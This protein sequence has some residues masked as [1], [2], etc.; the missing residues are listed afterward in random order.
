[1]MTCSIWS[2]V[3]VRGAPGRGSS[4]RPLSRSDTKRPRHLH[5]VAGVT[6]RRRATTLLSRP[7]PHA[8]MMRARRATW[9]ADRE[10]CA[11]DSNRRR[12]SPVKINATLGRPVRMLASL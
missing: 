2:S 11:N 3:I 6:W 4:Y 1:M 8:K 7:S 9:G 12:S 10:R 5:T